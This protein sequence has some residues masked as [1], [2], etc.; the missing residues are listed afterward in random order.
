MTDKPLYV[1]RPLPR[2]Q[3]RG[4]EDRTLL[5]SW[6]LQQLDLEEIEAANPED[7]IRMHSDKHSIQTTE[8]AGKALRRGRLIAAVEKRDRRA[9]QQLLSNHPDLMPL[10]LQLLMEKP[11]RGR[12]KGEKRKGDFPPTERALLQFAS[13][14]VDHIKRIWRRY[15]K[16][17]NR[18]QREPPTAIGISAKRNNV[19]EQALINWR[20][21]R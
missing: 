13:N 8:H 1:K 9:V 14:D 11:G 3:C 16:N 17:Q 4:R 7:D 19:S 20:K 12:K 6:T 5:E 21:N 2:W 15:F 18:S 10:A